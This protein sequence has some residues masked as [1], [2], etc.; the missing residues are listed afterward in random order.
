MEKYITSDKVGEFVSALRNAGIKY[1]ALEP[2]QV[3]V[4]HADGSYTWVKIFEKT[5]YDA[6]L[7]G[8]IDDE[9]VIRK[10][11]EFDVAHE[12]NEA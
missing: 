9:N 3:A 2:E 5:T 7:Q 12:T 4:R 10:G 11:I 8:I 6:M 1:V